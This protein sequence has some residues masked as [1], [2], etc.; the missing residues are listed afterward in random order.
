MKSFLIIILTL[1]TTSLTCQNQENSCNNDNIEL[2]IENNKVEIGRKWN[3]ILK[4]R[5]NVK[6]FNSIA[7]LN[8]DTNNVIQSNITDYVEFYAKNKHCGI[9]Y[10]LHDTKGNFIEQSELI[11]DLF[12]DNGYYTE[13]K[14]D[15]KKLKYKPMKVHISETNN[16][17]EKRSAIELKG[18]EQ[19]FNV[20]LYFPNRLE[21]GM[22]E[23]K[24]IY[25]SCKSIKD[26]TD[27][28]CTQSNIIQLEV[29]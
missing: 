5:I 20:Y 4:L 6:N 24:L 10:I 13:M 14:L 19:T 7:K 11:I 23:L 12:D 15:K 29:K 27:Y 8:I 22:Y 17:P 21:K 18:A 3:K 1:V 16:K 28:W 2:V 25:G 26:R 9:C